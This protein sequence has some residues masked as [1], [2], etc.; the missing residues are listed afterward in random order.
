MRSGSSGLRALI[1]VTACFQA[2]FALAV[3][4]HRWTCCGR[5]AAIASKA[6]TTIVGVVGQPALPRTQQSSTRCG[7]Y[8]Y[9]IADLPCS[10][11]MTFACWAKARDEWWES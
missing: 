11:I 3:V 7:R 8:R 1:A 4:A 6:F 9:R 5:S 10:R 2:D